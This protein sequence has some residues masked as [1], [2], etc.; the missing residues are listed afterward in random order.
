MYLILG[1]LTSLFF[2]LYSP[3]RGLDTNPRLFVDAV[4]YHGHDLELVGLPVAPTLGK[5]KVDL[6]GFEWNFFSIPRLRRCGSV[7]ETRIRHT[8]S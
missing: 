4:R 1:Y 7:F 8:I 5:G 3:D 2:M 6:F